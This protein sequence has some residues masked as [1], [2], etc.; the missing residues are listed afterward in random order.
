LTLTTC[1]VAS[2][3]KRSWRCPVT[4]PKPKSNHLPI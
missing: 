2:V 3:G 4:L 1:S